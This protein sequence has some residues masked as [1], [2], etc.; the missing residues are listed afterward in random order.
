MRKPTIDSDSNTFYEFQTI[1]TL[2]GRD[3]SELADV[4]VVASLRLFDKFEVE[5]VCFC[6]GL[7]GNGTAMITLRCLI[8]DMQTI[9]AKIMR[10]VSQGSCKPFQTS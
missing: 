10:R 4:V 6:D 2:E 8:S 9:G 3:L 7:D 1:F 5:L